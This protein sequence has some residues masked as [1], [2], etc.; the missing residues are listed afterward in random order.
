MIGYCGAPRR[1]VIW[2]SRR[3]SGAG[4]RCGART[5]YSRH[6]CPVSPVTFT[7]TL[8]ADR[9]EQGAD[10]SRLRRG[11]CL[12]PL[13][14]AAEIAARH[15]KLAGTTFRIWIHQKQGEGKG[16]RVATGGQ[17][18]L[19]GILLRLREVLLGSHMPLEVP[20]V[21]LARKVREEMIDQLEDYI[22]PRAIQIDAPLLAVVGG[23]TGAGKST[24]VNTLV[25][26]PVSETGVL[27]P[28]TRDPVLVHHPDDAPW[29]HEAR[30]LPDML[31]SSTDSGGTYSLQLVSSEKLPVGLAILDAPDVDSVVEHNRE[32]AAEL[33]GAA[34]LW[35]FVT[36]AA[37]YAD[38]VPWDNLRAAAQRTTAVA[39]VLD[40]TQPKAVREVSS[41]LARMM[42]ARRLGDAPLFTVPE[43]TLDSQGL[44]P[45][46]TVEPIRSWLHSM[47]AD[48]TGREEVVRQTLD[49]AVRSLSHRTREIADATEKQA[50][51]LSTLRAHADTAYRT[52]VE[53]V[54]G[55]TH[56]GTLLRG[57]VL[58]RWQDFV[59]SGD[60]IR[61]LEERATPWRDRL[62]KAV[63][64]RPQSAEQLLDAVEAALVSMLKE[65]AESAAEE[66]ATAWLA[67]EAGRPLVDDSDQQLGRASPGFRSAAE[68]AVQDWQ[69]AVF[70]IVRD[71][72]ADMRSKE[73]FVAY[74]VDLLALSLMVVVFADSSDAPGTAPGV[75]GQ[76]GDGVAVARKLLVA[77]LGEDAV[78]ELADQAREDLRVRAEGL[79]WSEHKIVDDVL[80][81]LQL[82]EDVSAQLRQ[83]VRDIDDARLME[84][85][86]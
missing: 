8:Q 39:M 60:L 1:R 69:N 37:R 22:L 10:R 86:S 78:R 72:G 16:E 9:H 53:A 38:Q 17:S 55:A 45:E 5:S 76:A 23:S 43:S 31:R 79:L 64:G 67:T 48:T 27:R 73:R 62:S 59:G 30:I 2:P 58:A 44:L 51:A 65:H 34:D 47:S 74:G 63:R 52:R 13:H 82:S 75:G 29:F 84:L 61:A 11:V 21:D 4:S 57:E 6:P 18:E 35:L 41:H 26:Q 32:L 50:E 81:G 71:E 68:H 12:L 77:V 66:T 33:L 15:A 85:P 54:E 70:R 46:K 3:P 20:D 19:L 14:M 24:L 40:R 56:D 49:G 80:H 36:S 7:L 25:G 28:T 42:S 83:M